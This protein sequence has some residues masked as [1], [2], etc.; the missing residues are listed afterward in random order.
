MKRKTVCAFFLMLLFSLFLLSAGLRVT[1]LGSQQ[2]S[3]RQGAPQA[4]RVYRNNAGGW[5]LVF[6]GQEWQLPTWPW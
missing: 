1:E 5:V 6:A 4:L 3:G 2:V